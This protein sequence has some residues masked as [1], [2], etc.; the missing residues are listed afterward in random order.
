M[1]G[2]DGPPFTDALPMLHDGVLRGGT[3][4]SIDGAAAAVDTGAASDDQHSQGAVPNSMQLGPFGDV[5]RCCFTLADAEIAM[6]V[7][8]AASWLRY[9]V[10]LWRGLLACLLGT[11]AAV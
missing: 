11:L 1:P 9:P 5:V 6:L 2:N 3:E 10:S 7:H 8:C 4:P